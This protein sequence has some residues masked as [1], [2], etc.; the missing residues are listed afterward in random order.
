MK[1]ASPVLSMV[2]SAAW[3]HAAQAPLAFEAASVKVNRSGDSRRSLG[4]APGGRFLAVNNTVRDL[5][6]FAFGIPQST[7][8]LRI[9]GGPTWIDDDRFDIN[10]KVEGAWT[11]QQMSDM[12]RALLVDRFH[13]A[14][15][16]ETREMP[17][18]ALIAASQRLG[19]LL[20]RS[21]ID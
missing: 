14:A 1:M 20:R 21:E 4:P 7:A 2:L 5:V 12:L 15:H 13:L 17:T 18:Y 16:R 11:P 19:P 9:V 3:I 10:A 6:P 8:S